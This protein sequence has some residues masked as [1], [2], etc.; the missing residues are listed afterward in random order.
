MTLKERFEAVLAG[1]R[2]DAM[3]FYGDLTYWYFAHEKIGDI[4]EKWRGPRGIGQIHKDLRVGEYVG[5]CNAYEMR[6]G[7]TVRTKQW[8]DG[9]LLNVS[10]ETPVGTISQ[11]Q[12][13]SA[14][15]FSWGF[16]EHAIKG[17]DDLKVL[18][19]IVEHREY[20]PRPDYIDQVTADYGDGGV[21]IAAVPGSPITE[22]NKTWTGIMDMCYML[23]DDPKEVHKTF[24]AMAEDQDR[25]FAITE[26][27][28]CPYVMICENLSA[29]TMGS[30]FDEYI[31]PYITRRMDG[32]HRHG[33]KALIHIDGK[34]RGVLEKIEATGVDCIDS[35][36][37]HP[38]GDVAIED[39][40][41]LAGDKIILLGGL[42]GAMFAPPFKADD[43][44]RQVR[45]LI[46]LHKDSGRFM[47]G[48]A[49][50]V[51]PNGD[52]GL[53]KLVGDLVEEY[54]RY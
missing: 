35:V 54:G 34:L 36:V 9:D 32:L 53:V 45:R 2:P 20:T 47:L 28:H 37:P 12:K 8:Q 30:Y 17:V 19:Y 49:D 3:A 51:P 26:Q 14:D 48:C 42:P 16:L 31:G 40:R 50:Q 33:K 43:M 39:L 7:S 11:V 27:C 24:Q 25:L 13:W 15:S 21:C 10:W 44:E 18:R 6:E 29:E 1:R 22:L 46:E 52:L 38:V 5:G 4:P 41:P 23:M